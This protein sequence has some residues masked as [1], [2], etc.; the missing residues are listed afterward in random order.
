MFDR[1]LQDT[2]ALHEAGRLGEAARLYEQILRH[3]PMNYDALAGVGML[4]F[5]GGNF[6]QA[7]KFLGEA[8]KV[9]V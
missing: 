3:Y 6:D 2:K 7:Q 5:Q 9:N 1:L 4:H 8:T